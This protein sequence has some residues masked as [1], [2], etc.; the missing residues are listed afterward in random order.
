MELG[1]TVQMSSPVRVAMDGELDIACAGFLESLLGLVVGV[2]AGELVLDLSRV[3]FI[4]CRGV[5]VLLTARKLVAAT[6]GALRLDQVPGRVRR[7]I[8]L[9]GASALLTPA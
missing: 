7:V 5:G 1:V 4:D 2:G 9:A 8:S 6:G 3:D